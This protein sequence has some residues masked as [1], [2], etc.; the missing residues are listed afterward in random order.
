MGTNPITKAKI[1]QC[2]TITAK[3]IKKYNATIKKKPF[4]S[5]IGFLKTLTKS[6]IQL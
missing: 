5:S 1:K 2:I 6:S 4:F 3:K